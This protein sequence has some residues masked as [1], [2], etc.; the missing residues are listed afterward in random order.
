MEENCVLAF[1]DAR[2]KAA[3]N[4]SVPTDTNMLMI[5]NFLKNQ[6]QAGRVFSVPKDVLQLAMERGA[7][8]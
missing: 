7:F 8:P 5:I 6:F 3:A 2:G 4:T 1:T